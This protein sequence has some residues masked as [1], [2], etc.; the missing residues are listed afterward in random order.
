MIYL[1]NGAT[2]FEKPPEVLQ[3]ISKS[4]GACASPGR[5]GYSAAMKAAQSVYTCRE[6]AGKL[7]DCPLEGVVF[8]MNA[9]HGLNI[10]IKSLVKQGERVVV[11]GFEHNAVMRPLYRLQANIKVAGRMLFDQEDTIKEFKKYVTKDTKAVICTHVSNVFG[12]TLPIKEIAQICHSVGVPLI[13][14]ASQSAGILPVTLR[15]WGAD[16]IAMP[17]HKGLYGPQGTGI[18]LCGRA[19]ESLIEGG[20]GS[21]SRS[22]EMPDFLPD[23]AESGTPNVAG[24]SGLLAGMAFV[25]GFGAGEILA[26]ERSILEPIII[27]CQK[28]PSFTCFSKDLRHQTGVLSISVQGW[29][30]EDVGQYL[31]THDIAVRAGL[32]CAPLA[33]ESANTLEM[34]TVRLSPSVFTTPKDT[35]T[36]IE[37]LEKLGKK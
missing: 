31:A 20:T 11:S 32:H 10:A 37:V 9:T 16:F 17:G 8:T 34:G 28:M 36:I 30:C 3:A 1:D 14:D 5:G 19:P 15:G 13:V 21:L 25:N 24:I 29:D 22:Y 35:Q 2:T 23:M 6:V 12:Y 33:H 26:H 27:K 18:L 4:M 7:F